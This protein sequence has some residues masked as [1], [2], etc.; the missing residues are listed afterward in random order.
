MKYI[1]F[2][3]YLLI[4]LATSA[5]PKTTKSLK[6]SPPIDMSQFVLI[7]SGDYQMGAA[8]SH[9][10]H[11]TP[12]HQ[13]RVPAYYI[14]RTELTLADY[15]RYCDS[16]H[17]PKPSDNGWGRD[18]HP[19]CNVSWLDAI[20]Y[21]NWLSKQQKVSPAY[22]IQGDTITWIDTAYGYRLPTEAEWEYAARGGKA[23]KTTVYAG[24]EKPD[25]LAWYKANSNNQSQ[26]V[27]TKTAN[28][29]GLYDMNG[30]LWEWCWDIYDA[31]YYQHSPLDHPHGAETGAYRVMRGGAFY[32]EAEYI[33]VSTRQYHGAAFKQTSVGFRLARTK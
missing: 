20:K 19:A 4:T 33:T 31:S 22:R 16:T 15:D 23:S 26:V 8:I 14:A 11:E 17:S 27:A 1:T 12:L 7:E 21:C 29:L 30:N 5:Q 32:N 6:K 13:V 28:E 24:G 3:I 25:G 2:C 10:A 18:K 9:E